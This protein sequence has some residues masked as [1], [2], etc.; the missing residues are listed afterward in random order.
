MVWSALTVVVGLVVF[1]ARLALPLA[2]AKL[3]GAIK[4]HVGLA[5]FNVL[6]AGVLGALLGIE[7]LMIHVLPGQQLTNVYAHAHLA[8][9]G[10]ATM[11]VIGA[12]YRLF[13]MFL[14]AAMPKGPSLYASA[15]LLEAGALGL[16]AG[17]MLQSRWVWLFA[18]VAISGL[19]AFAIQLA[20]MGR[21]PRPAPKALQRPDFGMLHNIQALAYLGMTMV[22]GSGLVIAPALE[23]KLRAAAAY[24]VLGLV[25]F[26]SQMVV[27][28]SARL[29]P[30]FA[31]TH[32]FAGSGF[33]VPPPTP[34]VMPDRRLQALTFLLWVASVPLLAAGMYF[35][36]MTLVRLSAW[37]LV[38]AVVAESVNSVRV[39]RYAFGY[40]G[41]AASTRGS[42]GRDGAAR[43]LNEP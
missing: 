1:S 19:L 23:W 11:M 7:K 18:A 31:W 33:A 38:A 17:L 10:W 2:R 34:H 27:G 28:M 4:L 12:G 43:T 9:L 16:F 29:W 15:I 3:P 22:L 40:R 42:E 6:V 21:N 25:G 20:W 41:G 37:G 14:P 13:P 30:M 8:A 32:S 26:L 24:G 35:P 5:F 36:D 39:L